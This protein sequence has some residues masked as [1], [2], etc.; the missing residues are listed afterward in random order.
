M[1]RKLVLILVVLFA[2]FIATQVGCGSGDTTNQLR[3]DSGITSIDPTPNSQ[4]EAEL[5]IK[6]IRDLGA[7]DT[8]TAVAKRD[9]GYSVDFQG[10]SVWVFGDTFLDINN[11]ENRSMLCNS[12]IATYDTDAGD[13]LAGF[14]EKVDDVG[15]PV[16]FF[17]LTE[18]EQLYNQKHSG[19]DCEEKPCNAHWAIWPGAMVVDKN[20]GW[21]YIFYRKVHVEPGHFNFYHVGHSLA[22]WKNYHEAAE[23]P[24]F[25]ILEDYPTLFFSEG[26]NGFGSAAFVEGHMLYVYGCELMEETL[27]K[28][29]RIARVPIAEVLK[30]SAWRFY[31]K[32]G[33]WSPEVAEA[34]LPFTA[35]EMMS[36]FYVPYLQRYVAIYSEPMAD[37]AMI[38]TAR[39][40][41]GPWSK[42]KQLFQAEAST[43]ETGWVYDALAHP[44]FSEEDGRVIYVT[45]SRHIEGDRTEMRLVA[46]E[47]EP[48]PETTAP[49]RIQPP[50]REQR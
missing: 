50:G 42:A 14:S 46:I 45:Y 19:K 24:V 16:E 41:E 18:A 7:I 3:P 37:K 21:A 12:W 48:S 2:V 13:G 20:K 25:D 30:R 4:T 38:R 31:D 5:Q 6:S 35:S 26:E 28:P 11:Q 49:S 29:C 43:S 44:E 10:R 39:S 22:I 36:V 33:K 8:S 34:A 9:C 27:A 23:R 17:P 32:Q 1:I 47:L 40:P 15:A